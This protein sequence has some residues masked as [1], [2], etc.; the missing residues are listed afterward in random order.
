MFDVDV[1]VPGLV[2]D[3]LAN[4][5]A[6]LLSSKTVHFIV[7]S[8]LGTFIMTLTSYDSY[9]IDVVSSNADGREISSASVVDKV[10]SDCSFDFHT[11]VQFA[12]LMTN[13]AR[14]HTEHGSSA[15]LMSKYPENQYAQKL[16]VPLRCLVSML[17]LCL[18][19][20][21]DIFLFF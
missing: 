21:E 4:S 15:T 7:L 8:Q 1:F 20:L 14:G 19:F 9:I 5:R 10:I 2:F 13:P 11:I 3:V 16:L 6:P 17:N 12:H 18:V